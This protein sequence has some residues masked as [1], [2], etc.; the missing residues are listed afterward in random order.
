MEQSSL[1][2][3][4]NY[5]F[6]FLRFFFHFNFLLY[7]EFIQAAFKSNIDYSKGKR[8]SLEISVKFIHIDSSSCE[9]RISFLRMKSFLIKPNNDRKWMTNAEL[10][11]SSYDIL[12]FDWCMIFYDC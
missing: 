11:Q 9:N 7:K 3:F 1:L 5:D 2:H 12:N 10:P 8:S 6:R 4:L